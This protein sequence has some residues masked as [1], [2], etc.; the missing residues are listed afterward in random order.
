M[1]Q[2]GIWLLLLPIANYNI[3]ERRVVSVI[4]QCDNGGAWPAARRRECSDPIRCATR[5]HVRRVPASREGLQRK[6]QSKTVAALMELLPD[7]LIVSVFEHAIDL[8]ALILL[9]A[10]CRSLQTKL[11][12]T[13]Q[14]RHCANLWYH[15]TLSGLGVPSFA[16]ILYARLSGAAAA[17]ERHFPAQTR[18]VVL[19]LGCDDGLL[20]VGKLRDAAAFYRPAVVTDAMYYRRRSIDL[21]DA[22]ASAATVE[23]MIAMARLAAHW[24]IRLPPG[25]VVL[26][27]CMGDMADEDDDVRE[28]FG[29]TKLPL[30]CKHDRVINLS[31]A[32]DDEDEELV[33]PG[34]DMRL[35]SPIGSEGAMIVAGLLACNLRECH[36][37]LTD[38]R[39]EG[40][41]IGTPGMLALGAALGG[42][43]CPHLSALHLESNDIDGDGL[44][45][46]LMAEPTRPEHA[47]P[48]RLR[49]LHLASNPLGSNGASV[50]AKLV[51]GELLPSMRWLRLDCCQIC[52]LG[53]VEL[54]DA[55]NDAFLSAADEL[56]EL[57]E[58]HEAELR[59]S[60]DLTEL[61]NSGVRLRDI[62][63]G[64]DMLLSLGGGSMEKQ[65][66][67]YLA[68]GVR[69]L[70]TVNIRP[71][72][73]PQ[74]AHL[75]LSGNAFGSHS[76]AI[77]RRSF[78]RA[79][80]LGQE[81]AKLLMPLRPDHQLGCRVYLDRIGILPPPD[82]EED[83]LEGEFTGD[84]S[85][86]YESEED[87]EVGEESEGEDERVRTSAA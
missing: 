52:G 12:S 3:S 48:G 25:S 63:G 49:R 85:E 34:D 65:D 35:R 73:M 54:A 7:E 29:R 46:L 75:D 36:A 71:L 8:A 14:Q 38:L 41:D 66:M 5:R 22:F 26:Y 44:F 67:S 11:R 15:D 33:A 28:F 62:V 87:E 40:N 23:E 24:L 86:E 55:L 78:P 27:R 32:E 30:W 69:E 6:T 50:I 42:G 60:C 68:P 80:G 51:R 47:L 64:D 37:S 57:D 70:Q 19:R 31:F 45:A 74:L 77:L 2:F 4:F 21:T 56:D 58:V 81:R 17:V 20:A 79:L 10:T 84:E 9:G 43:A 59:G 16:P 72:G 76:L 83:E 18:E 82:C 1:G 13:L 61:V 53:G 39:L